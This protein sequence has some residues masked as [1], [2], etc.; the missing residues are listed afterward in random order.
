MVNTLI[1]FLR[2]FHEI[3]E[4]E[5]RLIE[6]AVE[7]RYY[8]EG[9]YLLEPNRLCD[10]LFFIVKGVLRIVMDHEKGNQIIHFFLKENQLCTILN[11]FN[12]GITASESIEAACDVDVLVFKR[13][14]LLQLYTKIPYL[15]TVIDQ[16]NQQALLDKVTTRNGYLGHDSS[17]RYELFMMRQPE[18]ALRVSLG[19]IASYLGI[20]PQSL[21][22]IRRKI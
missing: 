15:K 2:S 1:A 7:E 13:D 4:T 17:K 14:Q 18:I 3:T 21:S 19:D 20:T 11:S 8:K 10:E 5:A 6:V 16:I 12:N 9:E 22:R